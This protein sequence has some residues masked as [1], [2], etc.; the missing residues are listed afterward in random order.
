MV[1]VDADGNVAVAMI[2]ED[3]RPA[4]LQVWDRSFNLIDVLDPGVPRYLTNVA[5]GLDGKTIVTNA[6]GVGLGRQRE[7]AHPGLEL[8]PFR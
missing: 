6:D 5:I 8:H 1:C 7:V 3:D 4:T 2:S